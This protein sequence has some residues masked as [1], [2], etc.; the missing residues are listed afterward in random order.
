[1]ISENVLRDFYVIP[2]SLRESAPRSH[3]NDL[4]PFGWKVPV[5]AA[6]ASTSRCVKVTHLILRGRVGA[7]AGVRGLDAA[8]LVYP[9][10]AV[11]MSG[12]RRNRDIFNS[13]PF[14]CHYSSSGRV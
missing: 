4:P 11:A 7:D 8:R 10:W 2:L 14:R 1:M 5:A 3:G 6:P 12:S 9:I 13:I